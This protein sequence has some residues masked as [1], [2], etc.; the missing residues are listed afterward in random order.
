[1]FGCKDVYN[2]PLKNSTTNYLVVEGNIIAG[3]DSTFVHLSRTTKVND[4]SGISKPETNA[5][6]AVESEDG[7]SYSLQNDFNGTYAAAPLN[8]NSSKNYRLH[9]FTA[10]GKEYASDY[11]PVKLTPPIDSISWKF[12][13]EQGVDIYV[14]THDASQSTQYYR[15]KYVA[16]WENRANFYS[17]LIYIDGGWRDRLPS[18]QIYR[19][20]TIDSSGTIFIASTTGLSNDVVQEKLLVT[21]PYLSIDLSQVYSILVTQYAQ[22][23]EAFEYWQ[24]LKKNTEQIGTIF[25]PQPFA[26]FGN[27]HCLSDANEPVLGF[28]SACSV[29]QQRIY[30]YHSQILWPLP[31]LG[32]VDSLFNGAQT[33]LSSG[34]LIPLYFQFRKG[35]HVTTRE[36]ADCRLESGT[37]IK[38]PYMP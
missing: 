16:A 25:D 24:N 18:E 35:L 38:P 2:P 21:I 13:A 23:K 32:C 1:M 34:A 28:I 30:I 37:T 8:I 33:E 36:C 7:E 11:V 4:T 6:I 27:I 17:S 26:E 12:N 14:N 15:W 19:C 31:D 22:T 9:I 5:S 3:N 20:W 29:Q 10:D